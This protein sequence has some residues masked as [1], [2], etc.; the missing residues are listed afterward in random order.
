ML[1]NS[2][3]DKKIDLDAESNE[4]GYGDD[5]EMNALD[6]DSDDS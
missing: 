2:D 5:K 6:D 4:D 1:S 3:I